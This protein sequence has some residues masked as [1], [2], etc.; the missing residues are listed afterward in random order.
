[1][2]GRGRQQTHQEPIPRVRTAI[3]TPK[4]AQ[5]AQ[6]D[7]EQ[8]VSQNHAHVYMLGSRHKAK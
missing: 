3:E 1:M 5:A 2:T 6:C 4:P 8:C 7:E